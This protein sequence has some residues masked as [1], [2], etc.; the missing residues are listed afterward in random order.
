LS[1]DFK[2]REFAYPMGILRLRRFF[3]K[4]QWLPLEKLKAYQEERL[5]RIIHQAY[6]HVPYY[7]RIFDSHGLKPQD[8]Q[9]IEHLRKLP[10]LSKEDVR[11]NYEELRADNANRFRPALSCTTGTT[12]APVNFLLDRP[13]NILEFV[14]YWRFFGWG[15]YRLGNCLADVRYDYFVR[16]ETTD[17]AWHF[18]PSLRRLL[19]N[20]LQLSRERIG[21]YADAL[22]KHRPRFIRG[23]PTNLYCLALFLRERGLDDIAFETAFLGGEI[24]MPELREM[25][26]RTFRCRTMDSY[27]HMERC[28]AVSQ[29]PAG[30]YHINL[31]YGI[32]ELI[33][34]KKGGNGVTTGQVVCTS[35]YKMAMPFLRYK[36]ED[37]L[38]VYEEEK[39]CPCGRTLPLVKTIHGRMRPLILTPDGRSVSALSPPFHNLKGVRSFQFIHD[40]P[41]RLLVQIVK[42]EGYTVGTE[43]TLKLGLRKFIG[44]DMRIE[45]AYVSEEELERDGLGRV[46]M[47][48]SRV[49]APL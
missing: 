11:A 34:E 24:A 19:L 1:V 2:V 49:G 3:E 32:L 36:L 44:E 21:E 12:G 42:T 38:E 48:M 41:G 7:R 45:L 37:V 20:S 43:E 27:S 26:E 10:V 5:R 16:T 18:Q 15:G 14:Y 28:V 40:E 30:G 8:I 23:R 25:I 35:L 33:N 29:C 39:A 31:E 13:A 47:V 6:H 9:R 17:K 4:S 46:Q 22:R